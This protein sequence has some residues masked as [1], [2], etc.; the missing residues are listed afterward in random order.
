MSKPED[1]LKEQLTDIAGKPWNQLSHVQETQAL[2]KLFVLSAMPALGHIDAPDLYN[3]GVVDGAG[4]LGIDLLIKCGRDVH[5]IQSKYRGWARTLKRE[6]IDTFQTVLTR[7]GNSAFDV[8]MAGRLAELLEDIEWDRDNLYFWFVTNVVIDNQ[9]K[10]QSE[11][12][13]PIPEKLL[14]KGLTPDRITWEYVD[15]QQ[16]YE[17]LTDVSNSADERTGV[18]EVQIYAAK[19]PGQGR[20]RLITINQDDLVSVIMVVESEQIARYCRGAA[21]NKLFDFNIRNYLG[22][23]R[24]NKQILQSAKTEPESFFLYNN[25]VS[26][27]CEALE[28]DEDNAA[29]KAQRFSVINGAQ[30]V[31][32]LA[33]L[34]GGPQPK[35]LLRVTEIPG[36]KDRRDLLRKVVKY[37]NTQNEIKSSDFRSNDQ[38]QVSFTAHFSTLSKDGN[39]CSYFA[40]RTDNRQKPRQI[41][42][43]E[44]T[45]FAKAVFC[46]F[47]NPYELTSAGSGILFDTERDNYRN[48]FG[49]EDS[50]I[51]KDDF[52]IKAGAFFCW[53]VLDKWIRDRKAAIK[54][55]TD[56]EALA[57]KNA[58]ERKTVLIWMLHMF[59]KRLESDSHGKFSEDAFLRKFAK[60][61]TVELDSDSPLMEFLISSLESVKDNV[62]FQYGQAIESGVTQR[63]WIRGLLGIKE[64][65][66]KGC[67]TVPNLTAGV[68]EFVGKV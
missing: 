1:Y 36:H 67:R 24:K 8:H 59:F 29:I 18:N 60:L 34:S 3:E 31:R 38:I 64:R 40:K 19:Q 63:Q 16:L 25:G 26:A 2:S 57:I 7:L 21:K 37:N 6:D 43:I 56:D 41:Y 53:E 52:L 5:I 58:L 17:I 66:E 14:Q 65:L 54:E 27:I 44:M 33:K 22:E 62:V 45:A 61:N 30:T 32:S 46:Y 49:T 15:Q 68:K 39:K 10:A 47:N 28:I 42:K 55:R 4:D 12:E 50:S 35:I 23:V 20:T 51:T 48:I 9:A 13:V 11:L